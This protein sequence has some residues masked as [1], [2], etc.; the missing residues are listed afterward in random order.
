MH[1]SWRL[2]K[3]RDERRGSQP[4]AA[5]SKLGPQ[6]PQEVVQVGCNDA[7][8]LQWDDT[9]I[10]EQRPYE[11]AIRR[12][13]R[14]DGE[15]EKVGLHT[16]LVLRSRV[17]HR[18]DQSLQKDDVAQIHAVDELSLPLASPPTLDLYNS[19]SRG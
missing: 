12:R 14:R 2:D 13:L 5:A 17:G 18:H 15:E 1:H 4:V 9:R 7:A 3:P 19:V 6:A 8:D 11:H 10:R 16:A